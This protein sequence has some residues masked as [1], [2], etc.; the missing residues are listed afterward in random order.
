MSIKYPTSGS[1]NNFYNNRSR[2]IANL[3]SYFQN[4]DNNNNNNTSKSNKRRETTHLE[5]Y[6]NN[7]NF[8]PGGRPIPTPRSQKHQEEQQL[9]Q[10]HQTSTV[11]LSDTKTP[12]KSQPPFTSTE[13]EQKVQPP[14]YYRIKIWPRNIR[15]W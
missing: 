5:N 12:S 9:K 6:Y 2:E 10:L 8:L 14:N 7:F 4:N 15:F 13:S 3:Q 1:D 11:T